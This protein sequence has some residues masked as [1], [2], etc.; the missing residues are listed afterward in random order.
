[1]KLDPML[2][3]QWG[4]WGLGVELAVGSIGSVRIHVGPFNAALLWMPDAP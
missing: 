4:L 2:Y 3:V 1:M